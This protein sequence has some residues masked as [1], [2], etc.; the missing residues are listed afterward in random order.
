MK[1]NI[2]FWS[3]LAQLFLEWE[4]F[5]TNNIFFVC[6][7]HTVEHNYISPSSTVDIQ[8]HVSALH[9]DHFQVVI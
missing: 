9:I 5:H 2:L 4:E 8:L 7:T 6:V 1:T 3:Y